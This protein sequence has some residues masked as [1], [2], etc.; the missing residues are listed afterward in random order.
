MT[1]ADH[2]GFD[3]VIEM[4]EAT[5][6]PLI[7][8]INIPSLD[9]DQ[10]Y[11]V[12]GVEGK[13]APL[14]NAAGMQG[15]IIPKARIRN[16]SLTTAA[17]DVRIEF[18]IEG[19]IIRV[20]QIKV[21]G[22]QRDVKSRMQDLLVSG[23]ITFD[24]VYYAILN[25]IAI[26]FRGGPPGFFDPILEITNESAITSSQ[27]FQF[28]LGD[29]D[30]LD[31]TGT[32]SQQ[33]EYQIME[34]IKTEIKEAVSRQLFQLGRQNIIPPP[35]GVITSTLM[36][37]G[38]RSL[39]MLYNTCN[40]TGFPPIR[41]SNLRRATNGLPLDVAAII[42]SNEG[43]LSCVVRPAV[44]TRLNL[45]RGRFIPNHPFFWIGHASLPI[46]GGLPPLI[47]DIYITKL[48]A[49]IDGTNLR[50]LADVVVDGVGG[51]FTINAAVDSTFTLN[52]TTNGT[53]LTLGISPL[54][55]SVRSNLTM[56][57]WYAI[58]NVLLT[59]GAAGL[60]SATHAVEGLLY[61]GIISDLIK[62]FLRLP[63]S[64][65]FALPPTISSV[66]MRASQADAP[67]RTFSLNIGLATISFVDPFPANDIIIN[68]A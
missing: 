52:A 11:F 40:N 47:S 65:T 60:V 29:Y 15:Q 68:I 67:K 8:R 5:I 33:A 7:R 28:A 19:T 37:N 22:R 34:T 24:R 23:T 16:A 42:I 35:S 59:G 43:F 57:W 30:I 63:P 41:R 18:D 12:N 58:A 13:L 64:L 17:T 62:P 4:A 31:P 44:T 21:K 51:G 25:A 56:A 27:V 2:G 9:P 32:A 66:T 49:G 6:V 26:D 48:L 14:F 61:G 3:V 46:T 50:V 54:P 20:N 1:I 45:S 10:P 55:P 38:D 36:R 53:T 39:F